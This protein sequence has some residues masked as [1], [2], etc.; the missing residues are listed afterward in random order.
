MGKAPLWKDSLR[1]YD[2]TPVL[3]V[4][5]SKSH[6]TFPVSFPGVADIACVEAPLSDESL[7]GK[8]ACA[9]G[10]DDVEEPSRSVKRSSVS[11]WGQNSPTVPCSFGSP[12]SWMHQVPESHFKV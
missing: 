1:S 8:R 5:H 6:P 7:P 10:E 12:L 11:A 2:E 9:L 4:G 3:S